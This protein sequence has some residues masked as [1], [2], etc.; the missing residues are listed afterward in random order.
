MNVYIKHRFLLLLPVLL[1]ITF[2]TF[3]LMQLPA[4]DTVDMMYK[5]SGAVSETVK[6]AARAELGLDRPL[7]VRYLDWLLAVCSGDM[8][9]SYIS[10]TPVTALFVAKLKPTLYLTALALLLTAC[11]SVPL[12]IAAALRH[13]RYCDHLIRCCAFLGNSLPGFF[14]A[15]LLLYCFALKLNF[16]TVLG[17]S[18][19]GSL[20]LPA[21]ALAI[22][23]SAKYIRHIRSNI[24]EEINRDY[25]A[26]A[27]VRGIP[28]AT[29]FRR[30][31]LR[32]LGSTLITLFSL[33]VGSLLGGTAIIEMIFMIDGIGKMAMDAILMR[34]YPVVQAY[35]VW[36]AFIFTC[37]NLVTDLLL[38]QLEPQA[39]QFT[40]GGGW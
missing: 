23:M 21:L 30:F 6:A 13:N 39:R 2:F 34:D 38:H 20:L 25:V 9:R 4:D 28:K 1:G 10:G 37:V 22:P 11:I 24:L 5:A 31:I 27:L 35:V 40:K 29:V 36:T 19:F 7:L 14:I 15:L 12:G 16:F 32:S 18:G 8:G 33:S 17:G 3:A 26:G